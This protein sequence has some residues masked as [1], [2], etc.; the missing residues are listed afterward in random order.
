MYLRA[1]TNGIQEFIEAIL[2]YN[3]IKQDR[4]LN[5]E[6]VKDLFEYNDEDDGKSINLL[7]PCC[8]YVLGLADFTGELMRKCINNLSS[9]KIEECFKFCNYVKDILTGYLSM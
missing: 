1:Y 3:Y 8:E 7:C 9:G 5:Y 2:F 6:E 4:I